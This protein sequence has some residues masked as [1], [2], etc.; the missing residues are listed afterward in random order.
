MRSSYAQRWLVEIAGWRLAVGGWRL[1]AVGGS[2]QLVMGGWWPLAAVDGWRLLA[3]GGWWST[4]AVL[5]KKKFSPL[6]RATGSIPI[7]CASSAGPDSCSGSG[8]AGAAPPRPRASSPPQ[9]PPSRTHRAIFSE[10]PGARRAHWSGG[11]SSI[12]TQVKPSGSS[13]ERTKRSDMGKGGPLPGSPSAGSTPARTGKIRV[14]RWP[15]GRSN[16]RICLAQAGLCAGG[17]AQRNVQS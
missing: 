8:R 14:T 3:V 1:A 9:G 5:H 7:C 12:R 6:R 10:V 17:M 4:G 11:T 16:D 13:S 15:P 2:W